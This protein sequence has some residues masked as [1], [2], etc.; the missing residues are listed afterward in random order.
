MS[1]ILDAL[2]KSE[3]ERQRDAVPGISDLPVVVHQSRTAPWL[4]AVIAGLSACVVALAWAWWRTSMPATVATVDTV[5]SVA[6]V[7]PRQ[8]ATPPRQATAQTTTRSLASEATRVAAAAA[9]PAPTPAGRAVPA[10]GV[11]TAGP[12]SILEARSSGMA[13]PELALE[14]LVFSNTPA[15]RFVYINSK[16]YVEG[17]SLDEGPRI[18]EITTEG[19]VLSYRGMDFL[20]P[21]N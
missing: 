1:F 11:M 17:D 18:V 9:Q 10:A 21:Q 20:L 14:L 2:K 12:V 5:P 16:K 19:V 7:L 8:P 15:Q 13:V 3:K 4:V 6:R